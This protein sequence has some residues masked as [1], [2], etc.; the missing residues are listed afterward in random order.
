[1]VQFKK[2]HNAQWVD[3]D[4]NDEIHHIPPSVMPTETTNPDGHHIVV[5]VKNYSNPINA[6]KLVSKNDFLASLPS[7]GS[8]IETVKI[9]MV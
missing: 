7:G 8:T 1:M 4:T 6:F 2:Y 9:G 5:A 3:A